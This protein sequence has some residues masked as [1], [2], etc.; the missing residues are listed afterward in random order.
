MQDKLKVFYDAEF[1]GLHKGSE[2]ISI[3]LATE[4]GDWFYAEFTDYDPNVSE[5]IQNNVINNLILTDKDTGGLVRLTPYRETICNMKLLDHSYNYDIRGTKEEVRDELIKWFKTLNKSYNRQIQIYC[6]C[7][8]Y[9]WVLF[10]DL[11]TDD[12]NAL[13]LPEYIYYIPMDLSTALQM[14]GKDPDVSRE[15]FVGERLINALKNTY[16]FNNMGENCKH[17][18][19]WDAAVCKLCFDMLIY[20]R[21]FV[22]LS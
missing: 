2:L 21:A 19:L 20:K 9:D 15:E 1:T 7:Y 8:A 16:P 5:W 6:D 17:N 11:I 10:N 13:S 18:S 22:N 3:G 14:T 4:Y 12:G